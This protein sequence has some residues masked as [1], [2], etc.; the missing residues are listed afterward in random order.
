MVE[1]LRLDSSVPNSYI[2]SLRRKRLNADHC[3]AG[4]R[5]MRPAP[6][7]VFPFFDIQGK[8]TDFVVRTTNHD[9]HVGTQIFGPDRWWQ[10]RLF[11][12]PCPASNQN[13]RQSPTHH[14]GNTEGF[15]RHPGRCGPFIGLM[16][17]WNWQIKRS[18]PRQLIDDL[19]QIDWHLRSVF[20]VFDFDASRNPS[21]NHAAAELTVFVLAENG[22]KPRIL[23]LPPGPCDQNGNPTKQGLDDFIVRVGERHFREWLDLQVT[24]APELPLDEWR[25]HMI[26]YRQESIDKPG[27]YLDRSPTGAGK[28]YVD[29]QILGAL[30]K[31][32]SLSLQPTH[33]NCSQVEADLGTARTGSGVVSALTRQPSTTTAPTALPTAPAMDWPPATLPR[34]H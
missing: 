17:V 7:L 24:E 8:Q 29:G 12:Q 2:K 31:T 22:A 4:P 33:I 32:N 27:T 25:N 26:A 6:A 13:T 5:T 1:I 19:R 18:K 28:S 21:V 11:S 14:R 23:P 3:C 10:R 34:S 16:G 30:D 15:V 9:A 20:V